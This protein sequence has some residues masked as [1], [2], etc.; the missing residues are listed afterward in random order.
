MGDWERILETLGR[1]GWHY[2]YI[3]C[4]DLEQ[5]TDTYYVSIR[6]GDQR[7]TSLRPTLEEAVRTLSDLA[8]SAKMKSVC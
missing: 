7:L 3:K 5:G 2:A 6:R 1:E 8:E 4:I